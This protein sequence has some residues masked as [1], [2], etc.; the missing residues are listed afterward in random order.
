MIGRVPKKNL[1]KASSLW[2]Q[3]KKNL[4]IHGIKL[5]QKNRFSICREKHV[6]SRKSESFS[7]KKTS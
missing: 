5:G 6:L 2:I 1:S 3:Y 7:I 4:S